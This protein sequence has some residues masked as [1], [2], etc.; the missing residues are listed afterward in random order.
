MARQRAEIDP[1]AL[2]GLA[3]VFC[4]I[5]DAALV[6]GVSDRTLKRYLDP[7]YRG[8][9]QYR[10][11]WLRGVALGKAS[12]RRLMW[13]KANEKGSA[14]VQMAIHLSKHVL[15][16]S[17]AALQGVKPPR[18]GEGDSPRGGDVEPPVSKQLG[19]DGVERE[20]R[21]P[22]VLSL[23]DAIRQKGKGAPSDGET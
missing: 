13:N 18:E 1:K 3:R 22:N 17:D 16:M 23:K 6:L 7:A 12:L 2:E 5:E 11:A 9:P 20:Y 14:G 19:P 15:G 4:T 10:D 8:D 21:G